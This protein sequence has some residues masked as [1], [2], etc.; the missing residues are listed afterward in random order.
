MAGRCHHHIQRAG[1]MLAFLAMAG[2]WR[3][4][5]WC[6]ASH[7]DPWNRASKDIH[8]GVLGRKGRNYCPRKWVAINRIRFCY[9]LTSV[10][11]PGGCQIFDTYK[12]FL[13]TLFQFQA[14]PPCK[15]VLTL[16][17]SFILRLFLSGCIRI[18]SLILICVVVL[19]FFSE[20]NEY[21]TF[22]RSWGKSGIGGEN[23]LSTPKKF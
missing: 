18:L 16:P 2:R 13:D 20:R 23:F 5:T 15:R 14:I 19:K 10:P 12:V 1:Q 7:H 3:A 4:G 17:R 9:F 21:C 22:I 11:I 8:S 6:P